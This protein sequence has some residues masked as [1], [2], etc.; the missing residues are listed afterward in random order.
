MTYRIALNVFCYNII[1][2]FVLNADQMGLVLL[3]SRNHTWVE[4]GTK[5]VGVL[6]GGEKRQI[7]ALP[8]VS[9]DGQLI[10]IQLIFGGK[11]MR[12][13]PVG[14]LPAGLLYDHSLSHWYSIYNYYLLVLLLLCN[15]CYLFYY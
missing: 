2:A 12:C 5:S 9:A 1:P 15:I 4:K 10:V 11:T 8:L 3:Q 6:A 7:T 13:H 14:A